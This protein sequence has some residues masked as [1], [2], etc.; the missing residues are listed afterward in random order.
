MM[1]FSVELEMPVHTV[2]HAACDGHCDVRNR[3]L[4]PLFLFARYRQ[5]LKC[6]S[7]TH[8]CSITYA[9]IRIACDMSPHVSRP[10]RPQL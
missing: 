1:I 4:A 9:K 5:D 3:L 6:E 2:R 8:I 10:E 7:L